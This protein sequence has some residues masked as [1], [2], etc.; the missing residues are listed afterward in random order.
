MQKITDYK[1]ES[2][3]VNLVKALSKKYPVKI[4]NVKHTDEEYKYI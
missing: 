2:E 4:Q 3:F 1:R